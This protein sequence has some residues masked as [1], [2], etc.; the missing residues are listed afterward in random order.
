MSAARAE[1]NELHEHCLA[2]RWDSVPVRGREAPCAL[3]SKCARRDRDVN[4]DGPLAISADDTA[5]T[6]LGI[7]YRAAL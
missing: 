1:R 6:I 2:V 7:G 4:L 5:Q 3:T